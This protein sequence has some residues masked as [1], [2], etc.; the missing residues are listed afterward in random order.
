MHSIKPVPVRSTAPQAGAKRVVPLL[1]LRKWASVPHVR[2]TKDRVHRDHK[3]SMSFVSLG[4]VEKRPRGARAWLRLEPY[5]LREP[6]VLHGCCVKVRAVLHASQASGQAPKRLYVKSLS[7]APDRHRRDFRRSPLRSNSDS[8]LIHSTL[9]SGTGN[10]DKLRTVGKAYLHRLCTVRAA[11]LSPTQQAQVRT[12]ANPVC[13]RDF[14]VRPC[15]CAQLVSARCI[16]P[17]TLSDWNNAGNLPC[18]AS[19][20]EPNGTE[21]PRR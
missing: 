6:H 1:S 14:N 18:L 4:E 7:L 3:A 13:T 17:A 8:V 21:G 16:D 2:L 19:E 10:T 11:K 15:A 20:V 5:S 12:T 9:A